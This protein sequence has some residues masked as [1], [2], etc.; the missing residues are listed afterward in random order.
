LGFATDESPPEGE[1]E[2]F[3]LDALKDLTNLE[4]LSLFQVYLGPG[5]GLKPLANLSKLRRL[6]LHGTRITDEG[7]G[8]M[9]CLDHVQYL[10]LGETKVTDD[11]LK[12]IEAMIE[13][14]ELYL[15]NTGV[16]GNG[17]ASLKKLTN[18]ESLDLRGTQV[19]ARGLERLRGL[20]RLI[21]LALEEEVETTIDPEFLESN[22][23]L[24]VV[25]DEPC[26]GV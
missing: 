4:E 15:S 2:A 18:L 17:L 5:E 8:Q 20:T 14:R 9:K 22:P 6:N 3:K 26:S 25:R 16:T 10:V 23:R 24:K 21:W 12:Q 1:G 13:L 7:F 11:C 19:T